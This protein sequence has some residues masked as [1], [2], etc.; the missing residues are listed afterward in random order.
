MCIKKVAAISIMI[1]NLWLYNQVD[2][3]VVIVNQV[4][5]SYGMLSN[6]NYL[7][8]SIKGRHTYMVAQNSHEN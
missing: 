5:A 6:I 2:A 3:A 1:A 8:A 4:I 7:I